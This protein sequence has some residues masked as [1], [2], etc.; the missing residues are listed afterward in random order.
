MQLRP[1]VQAFAELMEQ[2]LRANDH[3]GGWQNENYWWLCERIEE[4]LAELRTACWNLVYHFTP[5]VTEADRKAE[6]QREAADVAN[7]AMFIA[8]VYGGLLT[9]LGS[10]RGAATMIA[11]HI[12][13]WEDWCDGMAACKCGITL[14]EFERKQSEPNTLWW[15]PEWNELV[16][17]VMEAAT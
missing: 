12:H 10:E 4:E 13:V 5:G 8:D 3:K 1:E 2:V 16:P 6:I 14:D 9:Q 7:F 17:E 15:T 11:S